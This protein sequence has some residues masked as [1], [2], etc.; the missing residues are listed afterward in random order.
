M[1]HNIIEQ[2]LQHKRMKIISEYDDRIIF[3]L[4][5]G[6]ENI[7]NKQVTLEIVVLDLL[8]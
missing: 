6:K 7:L 4:S 8:L 5:V 1:I 3:F 2:L